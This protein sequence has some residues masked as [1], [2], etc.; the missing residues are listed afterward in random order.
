MCSGEGRGDDRAALSQVASHAGVMASGRCTAGSVRAQEETKTPA[1]VFTLIFM[2]CL[3]FVVCEKC[4]T[5]C[6][7]Y[8]T[9]LISKWRDSGVGTCLKLFHRGICN[10]KKT[11]WRRLIRS[12][13]MGSGGDIKA[14]GRV[15]ACV[16]MC[17]CV[18]VH[19]KDPRDLPA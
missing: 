15:Y 8:D 19:A 6:V 12:P 1:Y 9:W 10:E 13:E 7:E 5:T 16:C 14:P 4:G 3:S 18:H 2:K 17:A 11:F